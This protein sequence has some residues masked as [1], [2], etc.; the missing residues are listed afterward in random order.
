[1]AITEQDIN[2]KRFLDKCAPQQFPEQ[3]KLTLG[4][5]EF[6]QIAFLAKIAQELRAMRNQ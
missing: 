6:L 2:L 5:Y 3:G 4:N 1:M